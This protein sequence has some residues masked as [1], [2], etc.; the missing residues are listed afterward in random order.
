MRYR[1]AHCLETFHV[2]ESTSLYPQ[3]FCSK[4][5][6][7]EAIITCEGGAMYLDALISSL[8]AE[9]QIFAEIN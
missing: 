5:C 6:E 7:V 8:A 3:S 2:T 9:T 4:G 1:C